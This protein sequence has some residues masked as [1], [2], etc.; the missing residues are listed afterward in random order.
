[1]TQPMLTPEQVLTLFGCTAP[2]VPTGVA[3]VD[4]ATLQ[5]ALAA[6]A[7]GGVVSV[8]PATTWTITETLTISSGTT[9][10]GG[11]S[12]SIL[13]AAAGLNAPVI[14]NGDRT[15]GNTGIVIRDIAVD[16]NTA[17]MSADFAVIDVMRASESHF[18]NLDVQGGHRTTF[19]PNGKTGEGIRLSYCSRCHIRGGRYHHND[20]D[21]IKFNA[22]N[23]S[24]VTGVLCDENG[25]AG[26]QI[27]FASPS[28]PP[29]SDNEFS[30]TKGSNWNVFT[31]VVVKHSTG[32]PGPAAPTTSGIYLHTGRFNVFSGCMIDGTRQGIG[33]TAASQDNTFSGCTINMRFV[34]KAGIDVE[35]G[36]NGYCNRNTFSAIRV[37]GISGANGIFVRIASAA[38]GNTLHGCHFDDGGGTGTWTTSIAGGNTDVDSTTSTSAVV[39]NLAS[40]PSSPTV[41]SA[42]Y[43]VTATPGV[44]QVALSWPVPLDDGGAARVDYIVRYRVSPSG[45]W[46]DWSDSVQWTSRT[47]TVTGL[48]AGTAYDFGVACVN[49]VG[50][51]AWS[52]SVTATPT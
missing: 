2:L 48:S 3:A 24:T 15:N 18:V 28:G 39:Q 45:E 11:G 14:T 4:T 40:S 50:T 8:A 49:V 41:S 51:S 31:G 5:A 43:A 10:A 37:H 38:S 27:S 47:A 32:T 34:D 42:P 6:A 36:G 33:L 13:R 21:G 16:G 23:Y 26:I 9:L 25:R 20:Y 44:G 30:F 19:Y 17:E 12:T 52:S 7:G 22:T 29:W 35:D 1:M 46:L